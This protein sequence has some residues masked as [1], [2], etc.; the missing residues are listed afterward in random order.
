VVGRTFSVRVL[1]RVAEEGAGGD[2]EV[3]LRAGIVRE[4]RRYPEFECTFQHVLL[5]EAAL[6]TL[7]PSRR[8][9]LYGRVGSALEELFAGSVDEHLEAL[10][11]L[12]YRSDDQRKALEYLDRAAERT[13]ASG[14][15]AGARVL[16]ERAV[17]VAT[18]LGDA[19][20]ASRLRSLLPEPEKA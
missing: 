2:L 8:R 20:E 16:R 12:Y 15:A 4:V 6:S 14:D 9:E 3:L 17:K 5:Q 18:R 7:T 1:E 13:D 19:G 10:A 11:F